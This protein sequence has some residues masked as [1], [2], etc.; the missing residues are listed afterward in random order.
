MATSQLQLKPEQCLN[1]FSFS[2]TSVQEWM[3]RSYDQH[4]LGRLGCRQ[5]LFEFYFYYSFVVTN[6]YYYYSNQLIFTEG[7]YLHTVLPQ[8]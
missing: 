2:V 4:L 7:N 5:R 6:Y 1:R 3:I 8:C